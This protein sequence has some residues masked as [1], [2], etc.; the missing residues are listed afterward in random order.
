MLFHQHDEAVKDEENGMGPWPLAYQGPAYDC[1]YKSSLPSLST[2]SDSWTAREAFASYMLNDPAAAIPVHEA[3][4][5]ENLE[6]PSD[7]SKA[8]HDAVGD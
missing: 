6:E 7:G 2:Q 8:A 4:M 5:C 1:A 3:P